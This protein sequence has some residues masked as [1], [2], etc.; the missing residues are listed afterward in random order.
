MYGSTAD[1]DYSANQIWIIPTSVSPPNDSACAAGCAKLVK[2][3]GPA[4]R[5]DSDR[6]VRDVSHEL[7]LDIIAQPS[8][9]EAL[10]LTASKTRARIRKTIFSS[11]DSDTI[12]KAIR[13]S[14]VL[15]KQ[16]LLT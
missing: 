11:G 1:E 7:R 16:Y 4:A 2:V 13:T 8:R 6:T 9:D 14:L 15:A 12:L 3:D 5:A 10:R